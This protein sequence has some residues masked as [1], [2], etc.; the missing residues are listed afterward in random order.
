[1][2]VALSGLMLGSHYPYVRAVRTGSENPVLLSDI[3]EV[4]GSEFITFQQDSVPAHRAK[5]TVA[6]LNE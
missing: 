6:M 2:Y 4:S 3:R 1:M 5:D